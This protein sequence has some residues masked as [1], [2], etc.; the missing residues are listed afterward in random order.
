MKIGLVLEGGGMRGLYTNGVL[1][2]MMDNDWYPD[3]VIGVSAGACSAVSYISGQRGRS[4]RINTGYL[5]DKRYV[6][7]DSFIKTKSMFGM[8][9]IFDEIPNRLDPF[10]Y[11]AFLAS[12]IEMVTGVTDIET[13]M[14]VYFDKSAVSPGD[15]TLWRA[16]SSIPGF[17]PV[18][19]FRGGRYLDGG[20]SDPIPVRR[21]LADGCGRLVIVLT[22]DRSYQKAP[23]HFRTLY[24]RMFREYP[25]L[26]RALDRRH[27]IYNETLDFIRRLERDGTAVVIAPSLPVEI[28]RFEKDLRRLESLYKSG[29]LDAQLAMRRLKDLK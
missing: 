25:R 2:C 12:P 8:D 24:H 23:E 16:S 7:L 4:Y 22:R 13:G 1:D 5:G 29:M 26:A 19:S 3:Y 18:V 14:P 11:K 6:G 17:S 20:T 21:A 15:S 10:D 28:S 27:E 9:F